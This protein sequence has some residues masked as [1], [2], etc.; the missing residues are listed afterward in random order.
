MPLAQ[1]FLEKTAPVIGFDSPGIDAAVEPLLKAYRWPGNVRE[2]R[3]VIERAV[4]LSMGQVVSVQH[5]PKEI[6]GDTPLQMAESPKS[7]TTIRPL[8]EIEVDYIRH[9]LHLCQGNK[10]QAAELLGITRLTLRNK[11]RE[12][13][14]TLDA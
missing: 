10:T 12:H 3:N 13:G 5:L 14:E 4:I 9:V 8:A 2:L 1:Y 11:L 7:T 6:V